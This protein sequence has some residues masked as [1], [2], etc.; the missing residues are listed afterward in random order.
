MRMGLSKAKWPDAIQRRTLATEINHVGLLRMDHLG[1]G[2]CGVL[3]HYSSFLVVNCFPNIVLIEFTC[4]YECVTCM[5]ACTYV[6]AYGH[7]HTYYSII[8]ITLLYTRTSFIVMW[9]GRRHTCTFTLR[10]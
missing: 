10:D 7:A 5:C 8:Y 6:C 4:M 2:C 9:F 3:C 1:N